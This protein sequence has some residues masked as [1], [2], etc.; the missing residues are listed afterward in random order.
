[1][2]RNLVLLNALCLF[3]SVT[4]YIAVIGAAAPVYGKAALAELNLFFMASTAIGIFTFGF[5]RKRF[6]DVSLRRSWIA[7]L[8]VNGISIAAL[9]PV[10]TAG[11][12]FS[13][14]FAF[15]CLFTLTN[16][17]LTGLLFYYIVR[18]IPP[19]RQGFCIGAFLACAHFL[20]FL[21]DSLIRIFG[22]PS[23]Y[24]LWFLFPAL[25]VAARLLLPLKAAEREA[26]ERR[27]E[28]DPFLLRHA[29]LVLIAV[30]LL[31]LT[32]G[33]SDS[34]FL[35]Q[36]E[37]HTEWFRYTRFVNVSGF[38]L[39]GWLADSCPVYL[40]MA[41]LLART[42]SLSFCVFSL[43]GGA[44]SLCSI[45]D[46]FFT[47]FLIVFVIW[48]FIIVAPYMP[49]AEHWAGMGRM[50]ELPCGAAGA[51]L[52]VALLQRLPV[53]LT[54]LVYVILLV[55][56]GAMFY[57]AMLGWYKNAN[58]PVVFATVET[59]R[60]ESEPSFHEGN[61]SFPL[62][63][64]ANGKQQERDGSFL[65]EEEAIFSQPTTGWGEAHCSPS[66]RGRGETAIEE[67]DPAPVGDFSVRDTA[68]MQ[69]TN[70]A[71]TTPFGAARFSATGFAE[72]ENAT[73]EAN[74]S[75]QP[76]L[77][78]IF[79]MTPEQLERQLRIFK[80]FYRLTRRETEVLRELTWERSIQEIAE[81]LDI[82]QRTVKYH[83]SNLFQKTNVKTQ[84]EL[85]RALRKQKRRF[86][87]GLDPLPLDENEEDE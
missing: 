52:G 87:K 50:V 3:A 67:T 20:L 68:L 10:L 27:P 48:L 57:Q 43:E 33:F 38:L 22:S 79:N 24:A 54:F 37:E 9:L 85:K 60:N 53:S 18:C 13:L 21:S 29:S 63:P 30:A 25:A 31:S 82:S 78:P 36:H 8:F 59:P 51:L 46:C 80:A 45:A 12:G 7:A 1:M 42:I 74:V 15:L 56:S 58:R 70:P 76:E 81:K 66:K 11:T 23:H 73:A 5:L 72:T 49:N 55:V 64:F 71:A 19:D 69:E 75:S 65:S 17:Y 39:A 34:L 26:P 2:F 41:A 32:V 40:P 62:S 16:G 77:T 14:R 6:P 28:P 84:K 61:F 47:T 86:D 4:V 35:I 44:V 83:I